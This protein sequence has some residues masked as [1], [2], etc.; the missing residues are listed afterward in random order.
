MIN[1]MNNI[2]L[3]GSALFCAYPGGRTAR[4]LRAASWLSI[5]PV[6]PAPFPA[7]VSSILQDGRQEQP[8]TNKREEK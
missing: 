3:I 7:G 1:L 5:S 4:I 6:S 2:I 8:E